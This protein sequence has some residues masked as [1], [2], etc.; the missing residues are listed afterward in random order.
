MRCVDALW[1]RARFD[2]DSLKI[3]AHFND[4]K[5]HTKALHKALLKALLTSEST[6]LRLYLLAALLTLGSTYFRLYVLKALLT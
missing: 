4:A 5:P 3:R 2:Q 1:L 6:F